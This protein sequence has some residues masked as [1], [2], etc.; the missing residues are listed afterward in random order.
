R[1][2]GVRAEQRVGRIHT[3]QDDAVQGRGPGAITPQIVLPRRR[4]EI[5]GGAASEDWADAGQHRPH[6]AAAVAAKIDDLALHA[7]AVSR[8]HRL[9]AREAVAVVVRATELRDSH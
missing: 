6:V 1:Y 4:H 9:V 5:A 7:R 3:C 8:A 2:S